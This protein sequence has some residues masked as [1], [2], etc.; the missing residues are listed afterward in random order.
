MTNNAYLYENDRTLEVPNYFN[1]IRFGPWYYEYVKPA[2]E[3]YGISPF[4][5][6]ALMKQESMYNP[7]AGSGAGA[8]GL[9]QIMPATGDEIAKTLHWPPDYSV[10]DL[11]RVQ[12]SVNFAASYLR[13]VRSY[14]D[15]SNAAMVASYNGGSGNTQIWLN[16]SDNDPDLLYEVVRYQETRDYMHN[17]YCNAKIY[18]WLYAK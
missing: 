12:V 1:H 5:L 14:F 3:E 15:Q 8:L 11:L 6:Y 2:A 9:M 10:S 18:E 13:R 4:I 7:W 16:S 17:I